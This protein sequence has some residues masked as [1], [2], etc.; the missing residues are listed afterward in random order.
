MPRKLE[1]VAFNKETATTTV[2]ASKDVAVGAL[3][4]DAGTKT[5]AIEDQ[6]TGEDGTK[7]VFAGLGGNIITGVNKV[8]TITANGEVTLGWDETSK[9]VVNADWLKADSLSVAGQFEATNVEVTNGAIDN[10][11]SL[12]VEKLVQT[13]EKTGDFTVGQAATLDVRRIEIE[14]NLEQGATLVIGDRLATTTENIATLAD[15]QLDAQIAE[16]VSVQE[17]DSIATTNAN[18]RNLLMAA[19]GEQYKADTNVG[20]YVDNTIAVDGTN[21]KLLVGTNAADTAGA[22]SL[23]DNAVMVIDASKFSADKAVFDATL[24]VNATTSVILTGADRIGSVK[25]FEGTKGFGGETDSEKNFTDAL[26]AN[27]K[28]AWLS[29]GVTTTEGENGGTFI[30]VAFDKDGLE[31]TGVNARSMSFAEKVLTN[32]SESLGVVNAIGTTFVDDQGNLTETG[33]EALDEYMA[34][35]AVAGTY[36]AAYDAAEQVWNTIGA[37]NIDR[38]AGKTNGVWADVFYS[39]N[40]AGDMYG[41]GYG[42][43]ADVY[44]G[45]LGRIIHT[46]LLRVHLSSLLSPTRA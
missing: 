13:A 1:P 39:A 5:V 45:V 44:G 23:G 33:E 41:N 21:G 34:L 7:F 36:N 42:Y 16:K 15:E 4:V 40:E 43:E 30:D 28:N 14:T 18:G 8:E 46:L 10:F 17:A 12:T 35:P 11:G 31:A 2:S 26:Q 25:L 27:D 32:G 29:Y 20:L 6:V 22:V 19:A 38:T 37:H 24:S 3:K 9:G